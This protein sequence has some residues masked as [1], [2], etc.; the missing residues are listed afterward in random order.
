MTQRKSTQTGHKALLL[1]E[2]TSNT[3]AIIINTSRAGRQ[4]A[5]AAGKSNANIYRRVGED[6][7]IFVDRRRIYGDSVAPADEVL[8]AVGGAE[9]RVLGH[10]TN[11]E[12]TARQ[13]NRLLYDA[14]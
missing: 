6:L 12:D 11:H 9:K 8:R 7:R 3:Q 2:P 1:Y 14:V 4:M 5:C 10:V 13:A